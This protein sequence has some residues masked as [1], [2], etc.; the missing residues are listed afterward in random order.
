[1]H[2]MCN[3]E[4]S[5]VTRMFFIMNLFGLSMLLFADVFFVKNNRVLDPYLMD[6][7]VKDRRNLERHTQTNNACPCEQNLH[8]QGLQ[9]L[10]Y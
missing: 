8:E 4:K 1:M 3:C 2:V 7:L 5:H 10:C 6:E 9:C